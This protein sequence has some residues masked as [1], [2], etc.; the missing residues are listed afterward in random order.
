MKRRGRP[1]RRGPPAELVA[2]EYSRARPDGCVAREKCDRVVVDY[3]G[4][5]R[6]GRRRQS[7]KRP[8]E[9]GEAIDSP[10]PD[11]EKEAGDAEGDE[12]RGHQSGSGHE[13]D[14]RELGDRLAAEPRCKEIGRRMECVVVL[15][16]E[17]PRRRGR[18]LV[19][20]SAFGRLDVADPA[21]HSPT[22]PVLQALRSQWLSLNRDVANRHLAG[23][24]DVC[25]L[26]VPTDL[27]ASADR[28]EAPPERYADE[29]E[30]QD[31]VPFEERDRPVRGSTSDALLRLADHESRVGD[32][33]PA[34]IIFYRIPQS[35]VHRHI[36]RT[37]PVFLIVRRSLTGP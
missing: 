14:A 7:Q 12:P 33:A 3:R 16:L 4:R 8:G 9:C 27:R 28:Y 24:I 21:F 23:V 13:I 10:R 37:V 26:V 19:N 2:G 25:P 17:R 31:A 5:R 32:E 30:G 22:G 29:Q 35:A 15:A 18:T 34:H 1:R 20:R 11:G 36:R 6:D